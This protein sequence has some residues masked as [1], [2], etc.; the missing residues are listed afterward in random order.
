MHEFECYESDLLKWT[1]TFLKR[2]KKEQK[3]TCG[4][5]SKM[6]RN[7]TDCNKFLKASLHKKANSL[8]KFSQTYLEICIFYVM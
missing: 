5:A 2:I 8:R 7:A 6:F 4:K 1:G 3:N